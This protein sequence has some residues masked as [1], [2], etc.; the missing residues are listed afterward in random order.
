MATH[1]LRRSILR[2]S[3]VLG[4]LLLALG[5]FFPLLSAGFLMLD[6][7]YLITGNPLVAH[8]SLASVLQAFRSYDPELYIPATLLSYQVDRIIGDFSPVMFHIHNILL[9]FG[10]GV[11]VFWLLFLLTRSRGVAGFTALVF[12]FHPIQTEAVAWLSARKD[13]LSSFFVLA[14]LVAYSTHRSLHGPSKRDLYVF[15]IVLFFVALLAKVSVAV[16]PL[17]LLLID[18]PPEKHVR[19]PR[20]HVPYW[21]LATIFVI[22]GILGKTA[23]FGHLSFAMTVLTFCHSLVFLLLHVALPIHLQPLY[24]LHGWAEPSLLTFASAIGILGMLIITLFQLRRGT[25]VGRLLSAFFILLLPI[26]V[27]FWKDGVVYLPSDR[28]MYLALI[29]F[30]LLVVHILQVVCSRLRCM[31]PL[32]MRRVT[33]TIVIFLCAFLT[34]RQ[35]HVWKDD[36]SL[37]SHVLALEPR[38]HVALNNL[39]NVERARGNF[40][41]AID[42][43]TKAILLKPG[44]AIAYRNAGSTYLASRDLLRATQYYRHAIALS[45]ENPLGYEGLGVTLLERKQYALAEH[46]FQRTIDLDPMNINAY[47]G[48]GSVYYALHD[49]E[50]ERAVY[51]QGLVVNPGDSSLRQN[52]SI[53]LQEK[54]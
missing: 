31:P 27:T 38:T 50:K 35:T 22:I 10:S 34:Y 51:E 52:L 30:L 1:Q 20:A 40:V 25:Q 7:S 9:H 53:L 13:L 8:P 12:L 2:I 39:G 49:R 19:V 36:A 28:Y 18:A 41:Q 47:I 5:T 37:F 15:S 43:Y 3:L 54:K 42:Y 14:S 26:G 33:A 29:P 48:L 24:V 45:S 46:A 16:L 32:F 44:F 11:L 4:I 23:S 17:I 21:V 6:D